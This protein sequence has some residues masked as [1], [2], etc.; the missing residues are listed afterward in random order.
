MLWPDSWGFSLG[1]MR[2]DYVGSRL[3]IGKGLNAF[4]LFDAFLAGWKRSRR[5]NGRRE[6]W[7][8]NWRERQRKSE[9]EF[10]SSTGVSTQ[11]A[12]PPQKGHATIIF[13]LVKG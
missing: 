10:V 4:V 1:F 8:Q 11:Q 9:R 2:L 3:G 5:S 7:E 6:E 13:P 12:P